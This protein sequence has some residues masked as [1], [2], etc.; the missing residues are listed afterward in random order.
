MKWF[1]NILGGLL[2][3]VG[4][5]WIL[6]GVN[7]LPGSFMSGQSLYAVLGL[8]LAVIGGTL[9][10]LANRRPKLPGEKNRP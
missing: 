6:Q 1:L 10:F 2:A 4:V 5:V 8:V 3:L 7:V 9:L